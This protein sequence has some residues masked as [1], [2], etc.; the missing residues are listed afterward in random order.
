MNRFKAVVMGASAGGLDALSI[1]LA[2]L[3]ETYSCPVII[4]QH[5]HHEQGGGL[6]KYFDHKCALSLHEAGDKESV[7]PGCVY[8]APPNYHLLVEPDRIF[9]LSVDEKVHYS[10]PS[11]DVLFE[12]AAHVWGCDLAGIVLTGANADGAY[13]LQVIK[14]YG[15]RTVVQD[16][17]TSEH[18][19][20]PQASLDAGEVDYILSLEQIGNLLAGKEIHE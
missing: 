12:S 8:F 11:I 3:P 6:V 9:S 1:L 18:P 19:L 14:E 15:G 10:R 4:V 16:P 2:Y 17:A 7:R 5:V 13:G 20:M